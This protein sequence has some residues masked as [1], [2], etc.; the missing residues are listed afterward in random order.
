MLEAEGDALFFLVDI[1]HDDFDLLADFEQ[2]AGMSES[3]PRHIGD[4]EQTIHAIEVDECAEVCDVFDGAVD[5]VADVHAV[6]ELLA[7]FAALLLDHFAAGENNV[8]PVVVD[9]D[10]LE[11]VSVADELLQILWRN[12]IDLRRGQKCFDA[13][14]DHQSAFDDRFDFAFDQA[15]TLENLNDLVPVLPVGGFFLGEDDHAFVVF[16]PFQ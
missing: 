3:T 8:L 16:Q 9:F 1:E 15:V 5:A 7:L 14:V 6:Q 10:D 13:D 12:D 11:I 2:F 4:V